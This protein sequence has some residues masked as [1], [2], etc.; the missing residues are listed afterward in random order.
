MVPMLGEPWANVSV[1]S[2]VWRVYSFTPWPALLS[3]GNAF[4]R[5]CVRACSQP[6]RRSSGLAIVGSVCRTSLVC[7]TPLKNA[8]ILG[9]GGG[10]SFALSAMSAPARGDDVPCH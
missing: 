7:S 10:G 6:P 3:H 4:V 5:A 2:F 8:L 1:H 9:G